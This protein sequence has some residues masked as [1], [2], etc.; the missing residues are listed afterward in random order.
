MSLFAHLPAASQKA[1]D[2]PAA[3][4]LARAIRWVTGNHLALLEAPPLPVECRAYLVS[5][6]TARVYLVNYGVA[7]DGK[8]TDLQNISVSLALPKGRSLAAVT[9]YSTHPP[10]QQDVSF[11]H[12]HKT[13][14][15][16]A[17]LTVP[18]LH[19]WVVLDLALQAE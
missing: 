11:Q 8:V 13:D 17:T 10:R 7:K 4:K 18:H 6:D 14:G 16:T 9:A 3:S 19:I 2:Q 12:A 1:L 5:E 15:L